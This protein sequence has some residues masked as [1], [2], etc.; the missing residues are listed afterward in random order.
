M[1]GAC[2]QD[3]PWG[4]ATQTAVR[5][6]GVGLNQARVF[7]LGRHGCQLDATPVVLQL[8]IQT[9]LMQPAVVSTRTS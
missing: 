3:E 9:C 5:A 6:R 8:P 4:S 1:D 2:Q 7:R